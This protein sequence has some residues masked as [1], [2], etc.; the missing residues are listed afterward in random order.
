MKKLFIITAFSL[1]VAATT[2]CGRSGCANE[3]NLFLQSENTKVIPD[4]ALN[5]IGQLLDYFQAAYCGNGE[6]SYPVIYYDLKKQEIV[7][8]NGR[9]VI[10]VSVEPVICAGQPEYDFNR[11]LEIMLDGNN[12]LVEG[13]R[14]PADSIPQYVYYQYLS[15][16]KKTGFSQSPQGNGIWLI[17]EIQRPVKDFNKIIGRIIRGYI[18]TAGIFCDAIYDKKICDLTAEELK[19]FKRQMQFHLAFKFNNE[20]K[21]EIEM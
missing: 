19:S 11:I 13:I 18:E 3:D 15:F 16:G 14:M 20:V 2:S 21:M 6:T 10:P 4:S 8:T 17:S 12:I 5:S 7:S 9:N 1:A